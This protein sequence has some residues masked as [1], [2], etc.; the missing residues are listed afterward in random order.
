[1]CPLYCMYPGRDQS[2]P[3]VGFTSVPFMGENLK[4]KKRGSQTLVLVNSVEQSNDLKSYK[5]CSEISCVKYYYLNH[6]R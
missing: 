4:K 5:S 3:F 6:Y 2:H 1:M